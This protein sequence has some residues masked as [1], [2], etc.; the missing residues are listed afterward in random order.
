[1][2][3]VPFAEHVAEVVVTVG[4]AGVGSIAPILKLDDADDVQLPLFAVT[5]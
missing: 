3:A 4:A 2:V 5:V 1:M